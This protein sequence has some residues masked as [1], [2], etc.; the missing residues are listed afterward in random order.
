MSEAIAL[1]RIPRDTLPPVEARIA[2]L[3]EALP[4]IRAVLEGERDAVA[5]QASLACMLWDTLPWCNWV[6]FYR[7]VEDRTL[8][9]GPYHGTLGCLTIPFE[10]GVCGAAA[11][12]GRTQLVPDVHAFEGHIA[13]DDRSRSELVIPVFDES[14]ALRAVLDLDSTIP[15][16]FGTDEASILEGLLREA[17]TDRDAV[18]W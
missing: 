14:G 4:Q 13:C 10:R 3:R 16:A 18:R 8:K 11:R 17:F 15:D 1:P 9:V 6:G 7:R 2:R 5:L 12:T